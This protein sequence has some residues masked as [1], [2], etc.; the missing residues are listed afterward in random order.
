MSDGKKVFTCQDVIDAHNQSSKQINEW[1]RWLT[2]IAIGSLSGLISMTGSLEISGLSLWLY[3]SVLILTGLGSV[4]LAFFLYKKSRLGFKK[5]EMINK[6]IG[7]EVV[8]IK[9]AVGR[10]AHICCRIGIV[11]LLLGFVLLI[12]FAC[13]Y[14]WTRRSVGSCE[15]AK[16]IQSIADA[17]DRATESLNKLQETLQRFTPQKH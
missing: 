16:D 3:Y 11:S 13:E 15:A 1:A 17:A 8:P 6:Q 10:C 14:K 12:T 7:K 9:V 4:L 5:A 2:L